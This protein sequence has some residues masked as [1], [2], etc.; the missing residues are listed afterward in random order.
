MCAVSYPHAA[1]ADE[2]LRS[3]VGTTLLTAAGTVVRTAAGA[4]QQS[5]EGRVAVVSAAVLM[6][7]S[8]VEYI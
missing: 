1:T 4:A 6:G 3:A 7:A 5:A 8:E 2:G